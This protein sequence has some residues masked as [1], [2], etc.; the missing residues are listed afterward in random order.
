MAEAQKKEVEGDVDLEKL[1]EEFTEENSEEIQEEGDEY[2]ADEEEALSEGWKPDGK[3]KDGNSLTAKE[4]MS[5]RP[6]FQR[7]KNLN[8]KIEGLDNTVKSLQTH[9]KVTSEKSIAEHARLVKELKAAKAEAFK[10]MDIEEAERIDKQIEDLPEVEAAPVQKHTKEQWDE[11]HE[12]FVKENAWFKDNAGLSAAANDFGR[13]YI[14]QH[15][16]CSPDALYKNVVERV[17]ESFPDSFQ[18]RRRSTNVGAATTRTKPKGK[19][20]HSFNDIPQEHQAMARVVINSGVKEEEYLKQ[21]FMGE[22]MTTTRQAKRTSRPKRL[23]VHDTAN[24]LTV[25]GKE[26]GFVYR[27]VNDRGTRVDFMKRRGY[28]LVEDENIIVGSA[29]PVRK[30]GS[31][32][33]TT[34]DKKDGG[35]AILMRQRQEWYDEDQN[36]KREIDRQKEEALYRQDEKTGNYGS[37]KAS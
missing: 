17:K 2:T 10:D 8:E 9:N 12:V 28:E 35:Q 26:D 16:D 13:E 22:Q 33:S 15:P 23:T 11:R 37:V 27:W 25:E 21:Y 5:R 20:K 34:V 3:D 32:I 6:L 36:A 1:H 7:I 29:S 18:T 31:G 24:I 19:A 14:Q 30:T 4:Y